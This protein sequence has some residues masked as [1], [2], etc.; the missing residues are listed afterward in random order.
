MSAIDT[1][2]IEVIGATARKRAAA[3]R[4][5]R[6]PIAIDAV[7]E[8]AW[9]RLAERAVEPNAF[10][11]PLWARA[12]S[13]RAHGHAGAKALL[14]WDGVDRNRLIGFLPVVSAWRALKVPVPVLVAAIRE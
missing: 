2:A 7:S 4:P 13:R 10:Y 12:V 1:P 5:L 8:S 9:S 11:D 3:G 6:E 14:A